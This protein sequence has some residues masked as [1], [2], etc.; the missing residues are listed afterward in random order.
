MKPQRIQLSRKRGW[1]M[2]P[3]TVT[4]TR[5]HKWGNP[6]VVTTKIEPGKHAAGSQYFAVPTVADA[7]DCFRLVMSQP[8]WRVDDIGELRGKNLACWCALDQPCHA[9]ILIEI[10][11]APRCEEVSP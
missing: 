8:G 1:R 7:I 9:D 4:V 11:N 5:P 3:D 2:P 10:A 6:F